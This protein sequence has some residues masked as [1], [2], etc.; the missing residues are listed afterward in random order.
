MT[1]TWF[2]ILAK[3]DR[4]AEVLLYD[5]IG[6]WGV[7]AR[8]FARELRDLDVDVIDL[9]VNS[10]GGSVFDGI[11]IMNT[12]RRHKARVDVTVDGL[13]ASAASV[14]AMAG[15]HIVMNRGSEL[16][17]HEAWGF[18]AGD[19]KTMRE[20][21]DS[22]DKASGS[23]ADVY[24]SRAGGEAAVWR[25]RMLAET[26]YTAE[27]AVLAGL[28]DEW[29]D[30][31]AAQNSFD[32]SKFGYRGRQGAPAPVLGLPATRPGGYVKERNMEF[33]SSL[34]ERLGLD[35][36][37]TDE[38]ILGAI[39]TLREPVEVDVRAHLPEGTELV[40]S[41]M[42]AGL[43]DEAARGRDAIEALDASRREAIVDAAVADGRI[44]AASRDQWLASLARDEEVAAGLLETLARNTV[45]VSEIGHADEPENADDAL[46]NK[47]YGAQ[48]EE[49]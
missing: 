27:E 24:A 26:W 6:G 30:A 2:E 35:A 42:L 34:I 40:D 38:S 21:G 11:A 25:E 8:E 22:L 46:Y 17:I 41:E 47:M 10:P 16:M 18:A 45:P 20:M 23:I 28:A 9:R 43:R 1:K 19:A 13:A 5:E 36:E 48:N 7:S 14:V 15:D 39:D 33:R 32:L 49:V 29:V 12:L 44:T 4:H 37:A 3:A 31:P